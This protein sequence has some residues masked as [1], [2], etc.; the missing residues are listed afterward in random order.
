MRGPENT[1]RAAEKPRD[2][3]NIPHGGPELRK[4]IVAALAPHAAE[5]LRKKNKKKET[6]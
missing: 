5:K 4:A 6:M 1:E 3:D 2:E